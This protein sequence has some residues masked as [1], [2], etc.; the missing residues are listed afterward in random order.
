MPSVPAKILIG[1]S[2]DPDESKQ[3]L[4][5]AISVLAHPNDNIV[6]IHVLGQSKRESVTKSQSQLR[7]AKAYV[8]SVLGEFART[9]QSKQ[10]N[11]EAKVIFCSS[12]GRGLVEEAKSIFADYLLLC[13]SR[14]QSNR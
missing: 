10:V 12:I 14:N 2:S 9:C 6:A 3:L 1:I 13:S 11:L 8:I 4:S 5:R 7:R